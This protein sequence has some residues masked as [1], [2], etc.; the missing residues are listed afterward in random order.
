ML[1]QF[2]KNDKQ[3]IENYRPI[4]LLPVCGKILERLIYDKMFEFFAEN[5]V[6]SHNHTGSKS[7]DSCNNQ[8]LCI[9][10]HIYQSL[11]YSFET[12]VL[13]TKAFDKVWPE[14]LLFTLKQNGISG[15][16]VNVITDFL[17][18]RKQ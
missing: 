5:D 7:G 3:L 18:Q 15:N 10:H 14:G 12:R 1:F 13:E 6:N 17:C 2:I 11:D 8:L 9:T 4:S 16:Y